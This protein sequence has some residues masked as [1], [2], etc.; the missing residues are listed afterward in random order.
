MNGARQR[1]ANSTSSTARRANAVAFNLIQ[2]YPTYG[3]AS[4]LSR[5]SAKISRSRLPWARSMP[6]PANSRAAASHPCQSAGLAET[7][8]RRFHPS[9]YTPYRLQNG[10]RQAHGLAAAVGKQFGC[11]YSYPFAQLACGDSYFS[12]AVCL[13]F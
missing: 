12:R 6:S 7:P 9:G 1:D 2:L 8:H 13:L 5:Q 10:S 11:L 3:G 4:R